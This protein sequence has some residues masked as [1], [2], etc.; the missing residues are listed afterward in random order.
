MNA[1]TH[2]GGEL[3][4]SVPDIDVLAA[5]LAKPGLSRAQKQTILAI[6]YG[7]QDTPYNFHKSGFYWEHLKELLEDAG[8]C[9]VRRVRDLGQFDDTSAMYLEIGVGAEKLTWFSLNVVAKKCESGYFSPHHRP[10]T[11]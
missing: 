1:L 9:E 10:E 8:F 2:S 6:I 5:L 3:Y 7:G 4:V 11:Q